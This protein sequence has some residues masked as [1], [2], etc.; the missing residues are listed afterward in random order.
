MF[1]G[2]EYHRGKK[3]TDRKLYMPWNGNK[4]GGFIVFEKDGSKY[5]F[6]GL[7]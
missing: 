3:L 1:Y 2:L 6:H 7:P 4:F 5:L